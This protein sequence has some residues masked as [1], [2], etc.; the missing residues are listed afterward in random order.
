MKPNLRH[1]GWI[2]LLYVF[3]LGGCKDNEEEP[4]PENNSNFVSA[5]L[6]GELPKNTLQ[7]YATAFGFGNYVVHINYDVSFYRLH[8]RTRFKGQEIEAS[9]LVAVPRGTTAAPALLSAQHGTMFRE[10]D[11]P[12]NFPNTFS[13]FELFGAAGFVTAI[14]DYIG[15]GASKSVVHP[16]YDEAHSA[17]AVVD[18]L[19]A[20]KHYLQT[21][22]IAFSN[23]LF[24]VGYS[25]G[26]YV[27]LAAQ[28]EIET[29]PG[30]NLAVTAVAAGAGA[31]DLPVM[32]NMVATASSYS[33]PAFLV[34]M[35]HAY[36]NTYN[37]NRPLTDFFRTDYA[38]AIPGLLDGTKS[39]EQ[40]NQA[41]SPSPAELLNPTFYQNLQSTTGEM[42]LKQKL[43]ENSFFL[44][45]N[46]KSP[47]RLYHGTQDESVYYRT[48]ET[49]YEKFSAGGAANV[50]LVPIEGGTHV[51]SIEPMM[52]D[53][54][55]WF[56]SLNK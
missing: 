38:A 30:H 14:P 28:K 3:V 8:Y 48:T 37:W 32:M 52:I 55:L 23:K 33:N 54:L 15:M 43:V 51:S 56:K 44:T 29:T 24:L 47:T 11:A 34:K 40:I 13:G 42:E 20:T 4:T 35:V 46:P 7:T 45:W 17:A 27:T 26:G 39:L 21:Q 53:A 50:E 10:A 9:G 25:E 36:N 6:L 22:N 5:T 18:M 16:Y 41:L 1:F 31:Y 2:L 19:K 12:S 49:A